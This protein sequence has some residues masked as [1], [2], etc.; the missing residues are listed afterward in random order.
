MVFMGGLV[1]DRLGAGLASGLRETMLAL[2]GPSALAAIDGTGSLGASVLLF[3]FALTAVGTV[4]GLR[5]L[6][7]AGR[8]A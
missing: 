2:L 8:R 3:G 5:R 7:L 1:S 6:T 4:L